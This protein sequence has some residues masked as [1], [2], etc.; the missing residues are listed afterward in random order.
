MWGWVWPPPPPTQ[1]S[2]P[3]TVYSTA[4]A[5]HNL[6][7][8]TLS[9]LCTALHWIWVY[10][11][12]QCS[13]LNCLLRCS[14]LY[15]VLEFTVVHC[16]VLYIVPLSKLTLVSMY[17]F[18]GQMQAEFLYMDPGFWWLRFKRSGQNF[19]IISFRKLYLL[20]VLT[21]GLHTI[22]MKDMKG[23][24]QRRAHSDIINSRNITCDGRPLVSKGCITLG[25]LHYITLH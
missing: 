18:N 6:C 24:V 12:R 20:Q 9:V 4:G 25:T 3:G 21:F 14:T 16:T 23:V 5:S 11:V 13:A 15:Y 2:G 8:S 19:D 7:H 1:I 17:W 22:G 10:L